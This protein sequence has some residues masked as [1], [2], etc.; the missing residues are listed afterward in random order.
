MDIEEARATITYLIRDRDAKFPT[1]FDQILGDAG[2]HVVLTGVR[3]PRMNAIM[4]CWVQTC[5]HELLDRTLIW[6]ERHLQRALHHF[7]LHH[8]AHRPDQA[9]NQ[10]AP[11]RAIP[12]HS[13]PVGSPRWTY[14]EE[15]ASAESYTS[16]AMLPDLRG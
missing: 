2:I 4:E 9:M 10:A 5:R 8:N 15:T 1:P 11:L 3:M 14:A 12:D 13:I 16:T 7:E 6:N